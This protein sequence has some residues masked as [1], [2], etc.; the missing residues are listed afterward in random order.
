MLLHFHF[1]QLFATF[2][3]TAIAIIFW[4]VETSLNYMA[5]ACGQP[6]ALRA[7]QGFVSL[8]LPVESVRRKAHGLSK[9]Q[10][11]RESR[12]QLVLEPLYQSIIALLSA[13]LIALLPWLFRE[14]PNSLR[15]SMMMIR[16]V[17]HCMA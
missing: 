9:L 6:T 10:P 4:Y 14:R 1:P 8:Y 17:S 13:A 5:A 3:S 15:L 12:H 16:C 11:R 7:M 2:A